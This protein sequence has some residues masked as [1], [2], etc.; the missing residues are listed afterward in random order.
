LIR[1]GSALVLVLALVAL[2]APPASAHAGDGLTQVIFERMSPTVPGINVTVAYSANYQLLVTNTSQEVI[3]F[4]ADSGEPFLQIGPEGVLANLASPTFYNS[5]VP[6]GLQ[7]F[8][9]QAKPGPDVPPI[10]RKVAAQPSWGWYDHRLHPAEQYVPAAIQ[11]ANKLAVLGTW[12]VPFE[13]GG[14]RGELQGR[15]EFRPPTGTYAMVQK[16]SPT[17]ADGVKIQVVSASIVPAIFVENLSPDPVVVLGKDNEPFARIGPRITE[18]NVKS[19]T[20][21]EMRQALGQDPSDEAA[22]SSAEPKWQ[23]VSDTPRWRWLEF[24][25]AAPKS[26]P[27]KQIVERNRATTVRTWSIPYLIGDKK[28]TVEGITQFVPIA[29]LRKQVP[30]QSTP[31]GGSRIPLYAGIGLAVAVLTAGGWLVTSFL[32]SRTAAKGEPW[33]S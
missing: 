25:A 11:K 23:Q 8:P 28:G 27:P 22:D 19:P 21:A 20:W 16:S 12:K 5:N 7:R 18:V 14:Q 3:R 13:Y 6:E 9:D 31:G 26:D 2:P 29:V 4:L 17:P 1:R 24:R 32:R 15:F 33:T 10:W 30:G